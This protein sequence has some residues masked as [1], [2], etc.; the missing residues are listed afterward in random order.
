M[1]SLVDL[2]VFAEFGFWVFAESAASGVCMA[3][4]RR[5]QRVE[6]R[7]ENPFA[8]LSVGAWTLCKGVGGDASR[9]FQVGA[10]FIVAFK[11]TMAGGVRFC[12]C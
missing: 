6:L 4:P 5:E 8:P 7:Q 10:F 1:W 11:L 2:S 3:N 9:S 12:T